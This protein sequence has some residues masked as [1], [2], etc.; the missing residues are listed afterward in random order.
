MITLKSLNFDSKIMKYFR[1]LLLSYM[2]K[3]PLEMEQMFLDDNLVIRSGAWS[4][5]ALE[6]GRFHFMLSHY[7]NTNS[8]EFTLRIL[9]IE[10]KRIYG[11]DFKCDDRWDYFKDDHL[12]K[13]IPTFMIDNSRDTAAANYIGY[14]SFQEFKEKL[15]QDPEIYEFYPHVLKFLRVVFG[16]EIG[17]LYAT[18]PY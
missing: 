17:E 10:W 14:L 13:G 11:I 8:F 2:S 3:N 9:H 1:D 6:C 4:N 18:I 12:F 5:L 15:S 16:I 7:S